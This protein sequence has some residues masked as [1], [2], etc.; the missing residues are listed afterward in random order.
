MCNYA[1]WQKQLSTQKNKAFLY[2]FFN[3]VAH[4]FVENNRK[5]MFG[6]VHEIAISFLETI[7]VPLKTPMH[8]MKYDWFKPSKYEAIHS[9]DPKISNFKIRNK[10]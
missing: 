3:V 9:D 8:K 2:A 10:P 4:I 7:K 5:N 6:Y 1:I